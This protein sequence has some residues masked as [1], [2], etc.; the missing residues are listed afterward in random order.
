[1]G[2]TP[3]DGVHS[4]RF[5]YIS[6]H[7]EDVF[8]YTGAATGDRDFPHLVNL[9]LPR[10]CDSIDHQNMWAKV[11]KAIEKFRPELILISAGY[12]AHANDPIRRHMA[13][14]RGT[15]GLTAQ[16]FHALVS[17]IKAQADKHCMGRLVA[18]ME[19]GYGTASCCGKGEGGSGGGLCLFLCLSGFFRLVS[20]WV[21]RH[22]HSPKL[23]LAGI[24]A[25]LVVGEQLPGSWERQRRTALSS[26]RSV[27]DLR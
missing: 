26:R 18:V 27:S 22:A 19:G 5:Q 20:A 12:D 9:P 21:V 1:M 11:G 3:V 4:N 7:A 16:D 25:G 15:G 23:L 8:P 6:I 14:D 17:T 13:G 10:T 2:S 24:V